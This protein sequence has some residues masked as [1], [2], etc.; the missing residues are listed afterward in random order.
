MTMR[1]E[2]NM[3]VYVKAKDVDNNGSNIKHG[4]ALSNMSK[5]GKVQSDGI[6]EK[7]KE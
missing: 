3:D 5:D 2:I 4:T 7:S 6:R 1:V